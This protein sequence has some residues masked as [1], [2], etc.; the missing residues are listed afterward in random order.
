MV[1]S[2]VDNTALDVAVG[3]V[4]AGGHEDGK[5]TAGDIA[6]RGNLVLRRLRERVIGQKQSLEGN[7][8]RIGIEQF[9]EVVDEKRLAVGQPFVDLQS[10]R[11]AG[12]L[13]HVDSPER[14]PGQC[15]FAVVCRS[16]NRKVGDLQAKPHFIDQRPAAARRVEQEHTLA[17]TVQGEARVQPR[18]TRLLVGV[19]H[20]VFTRSKERIGGKDEFLRR[21]PRN[22]GRVVADAHARQVHR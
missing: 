7:R 6:Q 12:G 21:F 11:I 4:S 3:S 13:Q 22:R 15:P 17:R 10:G 2:C 1:G 16:A 9:D 8:R 18:C 14:R 5:A 19:Q 20:Q